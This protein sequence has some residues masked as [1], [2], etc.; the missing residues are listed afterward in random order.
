MTSPLTGRVADVWVLPGRSVAAGDSLLRVVKTS[1]VW[2]EISLDPADAEALK[3]GT[4][5]LHIRTPGSRETMSFS[6]EQARLIAVSPT[7]HQVT[8]TIT[9]IFE[10]T[11]SL[12]RLRIGS[13]SDAEISTSMVDSG[14]VIPTSALVEDGGV[15]VIYVQSEGESFERHEVHVVA[16]AGGHAIVRGLAPGE[17]LVTRGGAMIRRASMLSSGGIEGHVH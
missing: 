17:R 3:A 4:N 13:T 12:E 6:S 8:G 10:I 2:V 9:A 16:T 1:P 5:G 7:L 11:D 14:V 15:T